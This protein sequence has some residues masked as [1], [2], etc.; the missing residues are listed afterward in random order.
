[1]Y[2]FR[3]IQAHG[4]LPHLRGWYWYITSL[5]DMMLLGHKVT[6]GIAASATIEVMDRL[7]KN[8]A[9]DGIGKHP[10]KGHLRNQL[11]YL[12]EARLQGEVEE[13]DM[14]TLSKVASMATDITFNTKLDVFLEK[15]NLY[16]G[17][18][19]IG[20]C[21]DM[22]QR[23]FEERKVKKFAFPIDDKPEV[24]TIGKWPD[25]NHFYM[26]SNKQRT[27]PKEKYNTFKEAEQEALRHT[28]KEH[29]KDAPAMPF[30]YSRQGD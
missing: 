13:G 27:F 14:I 11:S 15:G 28:T 9:R 18:N 22:G 8:A 1:M 24:I 5:G 20:F 23:V 3:L 26:K 21:W 25:G 7:H 10:I 2:T 30:I 16:V 19:L 12:L 17:P 4:K 6:S 29:I